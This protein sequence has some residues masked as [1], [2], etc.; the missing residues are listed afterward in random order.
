MIAK[1]KIKKG[2]VVGVVGATGVVG[3]TLLKVL[4]ERN[5]S[6]SELRLFAS[7]RSRGRQLSFNGSAVEVEK[8]DEKRFSGC[9][10]IFFCAGGDI[11]REYVPLAAKSGAIVIDKSSVFRMHEN[12]PLVVPEVNP[13]DISEKPG[14]IIASP[15]C[16][17]TPLVMVLK[18]FMK[19]ASIERVIVSTYQSASGA[20]MKGLEEMIMQTRAYINEEK[21]PAPSV[22]AKNIVFNLIP[23]IDSFLKDGYTKEEKKMIDET[24]KILHL[25]D[26]RITATCVRVPVTISHSLSFTVDFN[27]PI[28]PSKAKEI[29]S[30]AP[31][32]VLMDDPQSL[33]YP[34]PE[35]TREKD[36]VFVGRIRQD[37]SNPNGLNL[38]AVT[39]N[40]RKGAA[41]NAVQI[42]EH[43][44]Q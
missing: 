26:L 18:P 44:C 13:E 22:F 39:D 30:H 32:I 17:T 8:L 15:N 36:S 4:E 1:N 40:L 3:R 6:V 24:R 14:S 27:E 37:T 28:S 7:E 41:T 21:I 20:G 2:S 23:Q 34:T 38:W 16:S 10:F 9:D 43:I 19:Y 5:F 33:L 11:S 12:I 29:L 25:P 42:A 35:D 31:G